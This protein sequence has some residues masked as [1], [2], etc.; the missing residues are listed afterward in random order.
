[1]GLAG[2]LRSC[3]TY[4]NVMSTIA[5]FL[6][7]GGVTYAVS[8]PRNSVGTRQLQ[9]KAVTAQKVQG[10]AISSAKVRNF[11]L[12]AR[13]FQRGEL[14]TLA[15]TRA[16]DTD[17]ADQPTTTLKAD[18]ITTSTPGR[19]WVFGTLREAFLTCTADGQCSSTWGVY[20]DGKPV[21]NSGVRLETVAGESDGYAFYT[22]Y[23]TSVDV[24]AGRHVI[25]L[26]R[27]D[28]PHIASVG[29]LGAQLGALASGG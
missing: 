27:S 4:S 14:P 13:D 10:S 19:I 1:M 22:L 15:A 9:Q 17:P 8:V 6:A 25:T 21:P 16:D 2:K 20:V 7:T 11:S 12:Q 29:Q 23:G 3:L 26:G 24:P 5:V 18:G 28:S